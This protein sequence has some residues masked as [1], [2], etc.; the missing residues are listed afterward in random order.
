MFAT[1]SAGTVFHRGQIVFGVVATAILAGLSVLGIVAWSGGL[2]SGDDGLS[3][4][5]G[6]TVPALPGSVIT[7]SLTDMGE[8]IDGQHGRTTSGTAMFLSADK[9]AAEHGTVSFVAVNGGTLD[10]ELMVLPLTDGETAGSQA[11]G[12]DLRIEETGAVG[13]ASTSCGEG[14]GQGILPGASSWVTL[15]LEPGRYELVCN[16]PG[17]YAAGMYA[18]FTVT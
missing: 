1:Q 10:H 18:E 2:N 12:S 9:T 8:E 3:V 16:L 15:T 5:A 17:H 7:V 11:I 13:E 4:D 14:P 6:C